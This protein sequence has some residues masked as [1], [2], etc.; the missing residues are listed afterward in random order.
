MRITCG[1]SLHDP[2][3]DR[4]RQRLADRGLRRRVRDQHHRHDLGSRR[5]L[6]R[7][8]LHDRLERNLALAHA[9]GDR[10][11]RRRGGRPRRAAR[12]SR[13]R[14]AA[15]A[16]ARRLRARRPAGRTPARQSPRAMSTMSAAT[17]EAVAS[18]PAPG[19]T[20]VS[21]PIASPSIVTALSTPMV[22]A[23]GSDLATMVGCTRCSTPCGVRSATPSSLMR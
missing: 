15:S 1:F 2:V 9:G 18:P 12:N 6:G 23:S 16:R 8:L 10:G 13:L 4:Q 20:S 14:G 7:A 5:A 3:G 17:A 11:H 19:P 21:E 22:C